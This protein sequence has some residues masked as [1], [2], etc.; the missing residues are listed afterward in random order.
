MI[1]VMDGYLL[2]RLSKAIFLVE[3]VR[4]VRLRPYVCF[5]RANIQNLNAQGAQFAVL[6]HGQKRCFEE[7]PPHILE[8]GSFLTFSSL[9]HFL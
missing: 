7:R 6:V 9:F 5:S 8:I 2:Q 4:D 1:M 3:Y